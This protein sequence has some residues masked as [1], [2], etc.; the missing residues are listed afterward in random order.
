MLD[1][2]Y[3]GSLIDLIYQTWIMNTF[4]YQKFEMM[5]G[6]IQTY[7]VKQRK[8]DLNTIRMKEAKTMKDAL[9]FFSGSVED[10]RFAEFYLFYGRVE[11]FFL[12]PRE[13]NIAPF[14]Y[15]G[16]HDEEYILRMVA[17]FEGVY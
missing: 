13:Q 6:C 11:S 1:E 3:M 8:I 5:I 4:F 16:F 10:E 9:V 15:G 17:R 2:T 12:Y 7:M 14:V